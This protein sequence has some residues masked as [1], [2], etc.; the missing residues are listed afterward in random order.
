M[1]ILV[2]EHLNNCKSGE[3]HRSTPDH[4]DCTAGSYYTI[5]LDSCVAVRQALTRVEYSIVALAGGGSDQ[6]GDR[7]GKL[8]QPL[9][10]DSERVQ[11]AVLRVGQKHRPARTQPGLLACQ[12]KIMVAKPPPVNR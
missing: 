11:T 1:E 3:R 5:L 8:P 6:L 12:N 7:E 10:P 4:M 9:R 2:I